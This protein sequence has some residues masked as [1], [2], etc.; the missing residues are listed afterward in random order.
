MDIIVITYQRLNFLRVLLDE[1]VNN[2]KYPYRLI[3]IDNGSTD[4]TREWIEKMFEKGKIW[5]YLFNGK[6]EMLSESFQIGLELVE[7][8]LF[9]TTQDD[10]IPPKLSPCWLTQ[11][12]EIIR[13]KPKLVAITMDYVNE[14]FHRY[15]A[16]RYG[17]KRA[18][19]MIVK[20][21]GI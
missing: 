9:I 8:E 3:I 20:K 6:N 15:L 19:A 11:M 16:Q 5:K 18:K 7:S 12:V 2:T 13:E 21:E 10:I 14:G 1:L 17:K 4:G